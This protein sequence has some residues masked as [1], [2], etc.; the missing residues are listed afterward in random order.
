MLVLVSGEVTEISEIGPLELFTMVIDTAEFPRRLVAV[1]V[2]C[3][4]TTSLFAGEA[5]RAG[6]TDV[7]ASPQHAVT[8]HTT[9]STFLTAEYYQS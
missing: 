3:D 5:A 7:S 9:A 8:D 4:K 1:T 6:V 2:T